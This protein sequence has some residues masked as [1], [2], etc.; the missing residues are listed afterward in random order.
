[1]EAFRS[2]AFGAETSLITYICFYGNFWELQ[3]GKGIA[4]TAV[5]SSPDC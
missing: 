3:R 5:A 4:Q 1:M 2:R